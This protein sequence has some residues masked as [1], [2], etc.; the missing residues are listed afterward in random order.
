MTSQTASGN[1]TATRQITVFLL[2]DHEV[3]RR[4]VRDMLEAE[5]DIRVV[6][7]AGTASATLARIPALRPNVAVLDVWLP[8]GDG[9][10]RA[11]PGWPRSR[12]TALS[13]AQL[14]VIDSPAS[15]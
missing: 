8:D 13:A 4:G 1:G 2:D 15:L 3:V 5:P 9:V 14:A 6:G 11:R 12:G 7:E 10:W